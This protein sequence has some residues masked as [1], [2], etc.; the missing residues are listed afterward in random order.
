MPPNY[1]SSELSKL[2]PAHRGT[3][4]FYKRLNIG[5]GCA[6][7]NIVGGHFTDKQILIII[8][9]WA[10]A[11]NLIVNKVN[12]RLCKVRGKVPPEYKIYIMNQ[13]EHP[14]QF[15]KMLQIGLPALDLIGGI[16]SN[17]L[18]E[19]IWI[20]TAEQCLH[21]ADGF[22]AAALAAVAQR[23]PRVRLDMLKGGRVAVLTPDNIPFDDHGAAKMLA[24]GEIDSI[25]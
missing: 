12:I 14:N 19:S 20:L 3:D 10:A 11:V 21:G 1:G 17:L 22:H 13:M 6:D 7:R 4:V 9:K 5:E 23:S 25:R 16:V 8:G 15:G 2:R 24:Q 18:K